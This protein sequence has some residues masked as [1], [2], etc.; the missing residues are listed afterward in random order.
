LIAALSFKPQ[1]GVL[2]PLVLIAS[3]RWRVLASAAVAFTAL[4]LLA[5]VVLGFDTYAAFLGAMRDAQHIFM[6]AGELPWF[7]MQSVYGLTRTLGASSAVASGAQTLVSLF[8]TASVFVLWRSEVRFAL[9]A[10]ALAVGALSVSPYVQIYDL[11]IATIAVL[12]LVADGREASLR[13]WQIAAMTVGSFMPLAFSFV[14]LPIGPAVFVLLGSVIAARS[15]QAFAAN[16]KA[17][18]QENLASA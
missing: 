1:L 12:F 8:V 16:A 10:A 9:K 18:H 7:K 17:T 6:V 4:S 14:S 2:I 15:V 5:G 3:G 11:P 13:H